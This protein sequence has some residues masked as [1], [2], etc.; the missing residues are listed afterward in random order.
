MLSRLA[1]LLVRWRL[2]VLI[3]A[4]LGVAVA[5]AVGGGAAGALKGGGF[6]DPAAESIRAQ[7][8]LRDTFSTDTPGLVFVVTARQGSVDDAAV[9]AFGRDLARRLAAEPGVDDVRSYWDLAAPSMRSTD[10][11]SAL[12]VARVTVAEDRADE[13]VAALLARHGAPSPVA[14]VLAGGGD[15]INQQVSGQVQD[16]LARSE[17]IALPITLA[18]LLVAF[19]S[20]IAGILPLL[21]GGFAIVGTLAV[22]F[23]LSRVTDVSIFSLNLT[24]ALG[25]GLAIDYSLFIVSR[26]RE[27]LRG[28]ATPAD[29]VAATVRTAG[30]TVLFSAATAAVALAALL[31]FPTYFLRSF[32]YAG[33][34]VI[35]IAALGAV[36]VLPAILAL[37]GRRIDWLATRRRARAAADGGLWHRLATTV[38]RRPALIAVT[39][40]AALLVAG[41]P[42][43]GL[44]L[45]LPDDRTAP[46]TL[47]S[48]QVGDILR[49]DFGSRDTS[50][51]SVVATGIGDPS[52]RQAEID[53]YAARLS[54][55]A[56]VSRVDALTGTYVDGRRLAPP[57]PAS[58]RFGAADATWLSVVSTAEPYS[59][60]GEA[61]VRDVRGL[62]APFPVPVQVAGAAAALVDSTASLLDRLPLALGLMALATF[63]LLF[64]MT[65]SVL[66]PL[67]ALVMNTL[68]LGTVYG[69]LTWIFQDGHLSGVLGFT[70]TGSLVFSMLIVLFCVL[71]GLSMDYEVFLLSRIK[72]EH[73]RGRDTVTAVARGLERT[74]WIVS[75]AAA[76][77]AIVFFAFAT[78]Q[79]SFIKMF[80]IGAG[81]A[82]VV[83]ATVIRGLLVPAVM[84]LAGR[85]NWWAPRPLRWVH[86]RLGLR[87]ASPELGGAR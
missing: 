31:V 50:P 41:A 23:L 16:D 71:F 77:I 9:A 12:L 17:A 1:G 51:L 32:A 26:F 62:P 2:P 49:S 42:V 25:L 79:V 44:R 81:L 74:G 56:T 15:V 70:A 8:I 78:S 80:G 35:L 21:V 22:L 73:D 68:S 5:G 29:A 66:I 54:T 67:K 55:V 6:E 36:V 87:E 33:I 34:A 45:G 37:L 43:L 19:G 40:V 46:P 18:L 39:V 58:A 52:A 30:R 60:A 53:G 38:M 63:V 14:T 85:A 11:R 48:R 4:L 3:L 28:G 72:E 13:L 24:T 57:S 27:E 47:S 61:L 75:T 10:S 76:L 7:A 20:V 65:G 64:L 69:V 82:V 83:D 84:R 59:D 86:N